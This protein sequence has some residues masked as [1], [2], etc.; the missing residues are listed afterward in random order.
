MRYLIACFVIFVPFRISG[1]NYSLYHNRV[2]EAEDLIVNKQYNE[3]LKVYDEV[4]TTYDFIFLS[5]YQVAT[6]I[7]LAANEPRKSWQYL[8]AGIKSGW[9]LKSIKK[10]DYLKNLRTDPQWKSI[11]RE[12]KSV[13][14]NYEA[15]LDQNVRKKVKKMFSKDQWKAI[16]VLFT[17]GS[18]GQDRY[19]EKKFA[20]HS[21]RQMSKLIGVLNESGY[22]WREIDWE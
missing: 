7:A 1:Q 20:R 10:N 2:N 3:A 21:E 16:G 19:A 4:F 9:T 11:K 12:Y 6:Q 5:D 22:P 14:S 18:K 8:K 15:Q 17:F 13:R